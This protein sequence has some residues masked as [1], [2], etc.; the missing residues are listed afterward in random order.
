MPLFSRILRYAYSFY[1]VTDS[2]AIAAKANEEAEF[3]LKV[4]RGVSSAAHSMVN[5]DPSRISL[6]ERLIQTFGG[7]PL[8]KD[9]SGRPDDAHKAE[10]AGL[11]SSMFVRSFGP[12]GLGIAS[13]P[14][15]TSDQLRD[16]GFPG[17]EKG[18]LEYFANTFIEEAVDKITNLDPLQM[19][20]SKKEQAD[21]LVALNN[22]AFLTGSDKTVAP[23][24][25]P[26]DLVKL[27][28]AE[29]LKLEKEE[30]ADYTAKAASSGGLGPRLDIPPAK[31]G[32]RRAAIE[33]ALQLNTDH[34]DLF[35]QRFACM[36]KM[37]KLAQDKPTGLGGQSKLE[38]MADIVKAVPPF[39]T[40]FGACNITGDES[41][42]TEIHT[43]NVTLK[44]LRD[45]DST[46]NTPAEI[47]LKK[48]I[49]AKFDEISTT[50]DLRNEQINQLDGIAVV[51]NAAGTAGGIAGC[52]AAANKFNLATCKDT[53]LRQQI[54]NNRTKA[55][56]EFLKLLPSDAYAL[57]LRHTGEIPDALA[58]TRDFD[59]VI[60]VLKQL[61]TNYIKARDEAV[62]SEKPED[63]AKKQATLELI[64]PLKNLAI[65]IKDENL[66]IDIAA[67]TAAYT[68]ER[69]PVGQQALLAHEAKPFSKT[70]PLTAAQAQH[71]DN[72][73]VF[74]ARNI[75]IQ[76][77]G[78]LTAAAGK[79][80]NRI[81]T[82]IWNAV[83][84]RSPAHNA[85][86]QERARRFVTA[87]DVSNQVARTAALEVAVA[88]TNIAGSLALPQAQ[89]TPE[90]RPYVAAYVDFANAANNPA[91]FLVSKEFLI[92][93]EGQQL[94]LAQARLKWG[95]LFIRDMA[96][97]ERYGKGNF[98]AAMTAQQQQRAD[99]G[100]DLG[101]GRLSSQLN[102]LKNDP[103]KE[104]KDL[105]EPID[106]KDGTVTQYI[107]ELDKHPDSA[108]FTIYR[109][110]VNPATG[111]VSDKK[112]IIMGNWD[113]TTK[114]GEKIWMPTPEGL[115]VGKVLSKVYK[116]GMEA[117]SRLSFEAQ[118]N[119]RGYVEK[120]FETNRN[121]DVIDSPKKPRE[122]AETKKDPFPL[123]KQ[124][125]VNN[126]PGAVAPGTDAANTV[127]V[128]SH[129][130]KSFLGDISRAWKDFKPFKAR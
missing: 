130:K 115:A 7:A 14:R 89:R 101:D 1:A 13:L 43:I 107:V 34:P 95:D 50:P 3:N 65:A 23:I 10:C 40:T 83:Y 45:P 56:D 92:G 102:G 79:H 41:R 103:S 123:L 72:A 37:E 97:S 62:K 126:N 27:L 33:E 78:E 4:L 31:A 61:E 96:G 17:D 16:C 12:N 59:T 47:K 42:P 124:H 25:T 88:N 91:G 119:C 120:S 127:V 35:A 80:E 21:I 63:V 57:M 11:M 44:Q 85:W 39:E 75:R 70:V 32:S 60:D 98:P 108:Y 86:E 100:G 105:E 36:K 110:K 2:I 104:Y 66:A 93:L 15:P 26:A 114:P 87:P 58:G 8:L 116:E 94:T 112:P 48:A 29:K 20:L 111:D 6:E 106:N 122:K 67:A 129:T 55:F 90:D 53:T 46:V 22:F 49:A 121:I 51:A 117:S 73:A 5:R 18:F 19:T 52:G 30:G 74:N 82:K 64:T 24:K 28:E 99:V 76:R 9:D 118:T 109:A 84:E 81:K 128:T 125:F 113:T 77:E 69:R 54:W 68:A 38:D 71:A